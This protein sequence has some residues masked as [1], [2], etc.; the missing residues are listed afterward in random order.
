METQLS[1]EFVPIEG[2]NYGVNQFGEVKNF[3]TQNVLKPFLVSGYSAVN[4]SVNGKRKV[5]YIHHLVSIAFLDYTPTR[6][7]M[8]I[9][10][11]DA[12]KTNP[13]L[14]NLEV[15]SHRRNSAL[16]FINKNRELPTGVSLTPIGKRR[17]KCQISYLGVNRYLGSYLTAQEASEVYNAAAECIVNTGQLPDYYMNRERYDR[18]KKLE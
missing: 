1:K 18:F 12:D 13:R 8:S 6:G 14:D 7:L 17:Y 5:A 2:S 9:N 3:R 15:I 4:I 11:R 10:H 16:T